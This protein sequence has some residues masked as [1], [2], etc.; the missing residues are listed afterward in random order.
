QCGRVRNDRPVGWICACANSSCDVQCNPG[1]LQCY[2]ASLALCQQTLWDF[3]DMNLGGY[4]IPNSPS[5]AGKLGYTS[6][7]QHSGKYS[8]GAV[9]K[10]TGTTRGYQI[11]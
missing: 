5:P 9:I 1:F 3:E 7:V 6:L 11:G 2:P 8:L 10:A 4:R